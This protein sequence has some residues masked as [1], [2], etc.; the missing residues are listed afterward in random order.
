MNT[1]A[2]QRHQMSNQ[3]FLAF[4][5][6]DVAYVKRIDA[7]ENAAFGIF[8]AD[9]TRMAVMADEDVAIA[10]IRQHDLQPHRLN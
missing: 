6:E 1:S 10:T 2:T 7:G 8:A 5:L 3:D 4:G 9:G